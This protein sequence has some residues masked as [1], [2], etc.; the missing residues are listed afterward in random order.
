MVEK[1]LELSPSCLQMELNTR[2]VILEG[3]GYS[4][5]DRQALY[6]SRNEIPHRIEGTH[7]PLTPDI[8]SPRA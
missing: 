3:W 2:G 6:D 5:R 8:F 4:Y 1:Q 7:Y